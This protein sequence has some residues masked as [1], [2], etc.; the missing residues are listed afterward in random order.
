[1]IVIFFSDRSVP[2]S[3]HLSVSLFSFAFGDVRGGRSYDKTVGVARAPQVQDEATQAA[4]RLE[5]AK[6]FPNCT[7]FFRISRRVNKSLC[8]SPARARY[9]G[10]ASSF[11]LEG[12]N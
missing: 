6:S 5:G 10:S 8:R 2:F 11:H 3:P 7:A 4:R 1:V 12:H 9:T